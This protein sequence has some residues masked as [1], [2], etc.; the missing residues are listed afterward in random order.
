MTSFPTIHR[1]EQ[2]SHTET[3]EIDTIVERFLVEQ[4]GNQHNLTQLVMQ[5]VTAL[6]SSE[7]RANAL[8]RQGFFSRMWG[9]LTGKNQQQQSQAHLDFVRA[10]YASQQ[11][12]Q[13]CAEQQLLTFDV[14]TAMNAKLHTMSVETDTEIN[15]IYSALGQFVRDTSADLLRIQ[16]RLE[17][18]ERRVALLQ[19]HNTIAYQRYADQDYRTL[20]QELQLLCIANDFFRISGGAWMTEDV[21]LL[22]AT[23]HALGMPA[24][25]TT[26]LHLGSFFEALIAQPTW[27]ERLFWQLPFADSHQLRQPTETPFLEA[28]KKI[29]DLKTTEADRVQAFTATIPNQ[30]AVKFSLLRRYL[31]TEIYFQIDTTI[32]RFDFLIA[33]LVELQM[34][35]KM[36]QPLNKN[37]YDIKKDLERRVDKVLDRYFKD[38]EDRNY[39]SWIHKLFERPLIYEVLKYKE[40]QKIKNLMLNIAKEIL[41]QNDDNWERC[42][43]KVFDKHFKEID[44]WYSNKWYSNNLIYTLFPRTLMYEQ[45]PKFKN[46]ILNITKDVLEQNNNDQ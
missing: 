35:A 29:R 28:I 6:T 7:A 25:E 18:T 1:A 14:I 21:L 30:N 33:V 9:L 43:D 19:W 39:N 24:D 17:K 32:S 42:Y 2:L 37:K 16:A 23:L 26:T 36:I 45:R 41:E 5:S 46:F 15:E 40:K 20:P 4:R 3:T 34:Y 10:Q 44:E 31:L 22:K 12:L 11:L 13:K 8:A 27:I 38:F